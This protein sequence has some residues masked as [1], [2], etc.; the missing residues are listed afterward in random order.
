MRRLALSH[1]PCPSGRGQTS[2]RLG[3]DWVLL[4]L[5][6]MLA[7]RAGTDVEQ[8]CWDTSS[9]QRIPVFP[10]SPRRRIPAQPVAP[11]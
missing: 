8:P 7:T 4:A 1:D 10:A 2:T 5:F 9:S 6:S 3:C 11:T